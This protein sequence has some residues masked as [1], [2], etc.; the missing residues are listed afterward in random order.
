VPET[1]RRILVWTARRLHDAVEARKCAYD[2]LSHF[3]FSRRWSS[4]EDVR[5]RL[6]PTAPETEPV[7]TGSAS[8]SSSMPKKVWSIHTGPL[9]PPGYAMNFETRR[10]RTRGYHWIEQNVAGEP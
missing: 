1:A 8:G 2:D 4:G 3:H 6:V 7:R 5:G 10:L 9:M